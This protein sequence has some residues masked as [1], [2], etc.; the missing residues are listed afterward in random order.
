MPGPEIDLHF[1]ENEETLLE[2][3]RQGEKDACTCLVKRFAAMV[4]AQA[5]RLVSDPDEAE[6]I[7]QLTFLKACDKI[8]TFDGRSG[9]G[10]WLYRIATNEAL[11]KLRRQQV[12]TTPLDAIADTIQ[13]DDLVQN[14]SSWAV[15]PGQVA[16]DN[17]L[18]QQLEQALS[19]LPESLR[20]VF[21]L[22][23]MQGLSTAET[24]EMLELKESAVKVRLHRARLRL[25]EL[26]ADYL[27]HR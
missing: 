2:G 8:A 16:L 13:P 17:E 23:E 27:A 3:L 26:L 9:L 10:T 24:A 11:M 15:N 19:A 20:V 7:L 4:Y 21:V 18:R 25:R 12:A 6:N 22:R 1:Y 5:L 14:R